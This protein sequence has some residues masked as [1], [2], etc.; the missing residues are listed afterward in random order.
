VLPSGLNRD[1]ITDTYSLTD[2]GGVKGMAGEITSLAR[3]EEEIRSCRKCVGILSKYG[4]VP[5]PIFRGNADLPILL[6]GQAPGK[7]EYERNAPF[8]GDAGASIRSLFSSCGLNDFDGMVYQTSVTKCFPGRRQNA[9]SDRKP[10]AEE[11][12]NC[13]GFLARQLDL[14]RPKLV[15]CLGELAWK[16]YVSIREQEEPGYCQREFARRLPNDLRL[17]DLVGKRF[18]W[19]VATVIPMIHPSGSANGAR[20]QYPVQDDESKLL[21]RKELERLHLN[22]AYN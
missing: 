19:R 3:L 6:I 15:V 18:S 14:L 16:S 22:G 10:S 12:R 1:S 9:S 5:R 8:Q 11:V 20:A 4:V 7:K 2:D 13:L 21:L 17:P